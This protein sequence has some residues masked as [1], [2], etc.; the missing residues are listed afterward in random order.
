MSGMVG[1]VGIPQILSRIGMSEE[2][3]I[4]YHTFSEPHPQN[5]FNDDGNFRSG[6]MLGISGHTSSVIPFRNQNLKFI[7]CHTFSEPQP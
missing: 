7:V 1:M 6:G 2:T 3:D 5:D 4:K